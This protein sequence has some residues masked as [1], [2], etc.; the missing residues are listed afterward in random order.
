MM[1][2]KKVLATSSGIYAVKDGKTVALAQG[3][4]FSID[5]TQAEKLAKRGKVELVNNSKP[6]AKK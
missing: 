3:V 6:A 2:D 4:E 1:A 5:L